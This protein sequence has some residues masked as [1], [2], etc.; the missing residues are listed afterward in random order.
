MGLFLNGSLRV[1]RLVAAHVRRRRARARRCYPPTCIECEGLIES[2][3]YDTSAPC[4]HKMFLCGL[5][6]TTCGYPFFGEM[7]ENRECPTAGLSRFSAKANATP[8]QAGPSVHCV[9][10]NASF[11]DD[12]VTLVRA[13]SHFLEFLAGARLVPVPLHPLKK[14]ERTYN[15][16]E[17]L[18]GCFAEAA[19]AT[20]VPMLVRV[21]ATSTQTRLDREQRRENLKN[22]FA[23]A[24]GAP[25]IPT[26]RHVLVDDVFTT[27]ATLNACAVALRRAGVTSVDVATLGHG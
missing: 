23:L 11:L 4:S 18:A 7:A 26:A 10:M 21:V 25:V 22:A 2:S 9:N 19:G 5:H 17:L 27:G 1:T 6:C 16:A 14:R 13:N 12:V 20:V 24:E 3:A 8:F 15:Q